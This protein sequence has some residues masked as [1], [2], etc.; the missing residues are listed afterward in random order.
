M[1][2]FDTYNQTIKQIKDCIF[3]YLIMAV[4][5]NVYT[6]LG[7]FVISNENFSIYCIAHGAYWNLVAVT[8]LPCDLLTYHG[9]LNWNR[10]FLIPSL[11]HRWIFAFWTVFLITWNIYADFDYIRDWN[12]FECIRVLQISIATIIF[13]YFWP[14]SLKNLSRQ[15]GEMKSNSKPTIYD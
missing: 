7:L 1:N 11:A 10:W 3:M 6:G 5:G 13:W 2:R 9:L 12:F 8:L 15:F 14:V 4:I